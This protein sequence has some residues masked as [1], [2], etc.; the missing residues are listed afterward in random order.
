MDFYEETEP[1][2]VND[3]Q[4]I[5]K[6]KDKSTIN[7]VD[8]FESDE[9]DSDELNASYVNDQS[10]DNGLYN[11]DEDYNIDSVS[12]D[13]ENFVNTDKLIPE[14][15]KKL[16]AVFKCKSFIH[17]MDLPQPSDIHVHSK[18]ANCLLKLN[19]IHGD[20]NITTIIGGKDMFFETIQDFNKVLYKQLLCFAKIIHT[21][22]LTNL[23]EGNNLSYPFI[24]VHYYPNNDNNVVKVD[25]NP[26]KKKSRRKRKKIPQNTTGK[27]GR[28]SNQVTFIIDLGPERK[29]ANIKL[30]CNFNSTITGVL[31]NKDGTDALEILRQELLKYC[32]CFQGIITSPDD[33]VATNYHNSMICAKFSLNIPINREEFRDILMKEY[34]VYAFFDP[35][36]KYQGV[37]VRYKW[38]K[39]NKLKDGKCYHTPMCNN[40]KQGNGHDSCRNIT[41]SVFQEGKVTL[42]GSTCDEQLFEARRFI[43][44]YVKTHWKDLIFIHVNNY[45]KYL[46]YFPEN[47]LS[48]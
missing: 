26:F 27:K 1:N 40:K 46:P 8:Q 30:F 11:I 19:K 10:I 3:L 48:L 20:K 36:A 6:N 43:K 47:I 17:L 16:F 9:L 4:H 33:I 37:I 13:I 23:F 21:N 34:G 28:F 5:T 42:K 15:Y 45:D 22:I 18:T 7:A 44:K 39:F 25:F 24:G 41:I 29:N 38:N 31:Y 14:N 32:H 35:D 2:S 12:D